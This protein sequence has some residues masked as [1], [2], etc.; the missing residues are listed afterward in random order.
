MFSTVTSFTMLRPDIYNPL[1]T[2][3]E[4]VISGVEWVKPPPPL[5]RCFDGSS[6]GSTRLGPALPNIDVMLDNGQNWTLPGR[7][8]LAGAGG[9]PDNI[10]YPASDNAPAII[11]GNHQMQDNLV[12]FDLEKNTFGFSGLLLGRSTHC[13]NFNFNTGSS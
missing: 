9:R 11:F 13:G 6:F 2:T 4:K 8:Q 10:P 3:F 5:F 1:L 7:R 12:Q